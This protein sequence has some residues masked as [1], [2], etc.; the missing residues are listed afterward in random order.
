VLLPLVLMLSRLAGW[1]RGLKIIGWSRL[2]IVWLK[3]K[4]AHPNS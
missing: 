1:L 2:V 4:T 3:Q